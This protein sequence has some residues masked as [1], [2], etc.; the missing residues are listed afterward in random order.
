MKRGLRR[1]LRL[2]RSARRIRADVWEE[3]R[4]EIDMRAR[5]LMREGLT[6]DAAH[7]RSIAEFGDLDATRRYCEEADMEIERTTRRAHLIDDARSDAAIAWRAMRRTPGFA[8][9]VLATLALGIGANT[10]VFSVVRRVLIAPLPFRESNQLYRLYTVPA[11]PGGDD[12]K[13][14]AAELADLAAESHS[15]AGVTQFGA[16]GGV[17]YTDDETAEPWQ[18]V[19]VAPNF[20]DVLGIRPAL[21]RPF[22]DDDVA[23]GT[24]PVVMISYSL[25]QRLFGGDSR[26]LGREMQLSSVAYTVIGVLP[27]NFVGP[28]FS[29]GT[30]FTPDA[31]LPLNV[32]GILRSRGSRGRVWRSVARLKTGVTPAALHAELELLRPRMQARYPE[33]KRAGVIRPVPL[34][35]AMAGSARPVLEIVMGAAMLVLV[36]TCVN[37]A[38]LFLARAAARKRELGVRAALGAAR[39]RLVRQVL[40]ESALYGVAGGSLGIAL[41]VVMKRAL[42]GL[43]GPALPQMGEVRLDAAVLAFAALVSIGCGLIVGVVPALAATRVDLRDALSESGGHG[44]SSGR[45]RT[46][47]TATL[48]GAQMAFAMVL[49]IGAGLLVRSFVTLVQRDVGYNVDGH[50]LTFHVNLPPRRFADV[51]ARAGFIRSFVDRARAVPGVT[52]VGYTAVAPWNGGWMTE[53][54][55]VDGRMVDETNVPTVDYETASDDFFSTIRVPLK[56]GRFF[57]PADRP[58]SVP[59]VIISESVAK[60]FWPSANPIGAR[61]HVDNGIPADSATV[62]EV[63]GVVGDVRPDVTSGPA[64]TVYVSEGQRIGYGGEFVVRARGDASALVPE[65]KVALHELDAK[66]PLTFARTLRDVF[67]ALLAPQELATAL[68]ASFAALALIL[69]TLGIYT[70]V[71]QS[72]T[73]RT[74]EFGIR[75]AL[76][77]RRESILL[78]VLRQGFATTLAGVASGLVL[79]ALAS[80]VV[81]SLLSGVSTHDAL[82]FTVAPLAL[83]VVAMLACALP[84]RAATR[85]QPV[86]ALRS[87]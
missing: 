72:V 6:A 47:A 76:G 26:V 37:I 2:P 87:E 3:L 35:D 86:D 68:M 17:T 79:A 4:Y 19:A 48:A 21:G 27:Q 41:A 38:G 14:S 83:I 63:V 31:L 53:G 65:L 46:R 85:V 59:V 51:D 30:T 67:K 54:F 61:V 42:I 84:A 64:A 80:R 55:R 69:A 22:S 15:L 78:L 23:Q 52:D 71:A 57:G 7:E 5:E 9:V 66:I 58:G 74:R 29:T 33:I 73:A 44:A 39:G 60:R 10:T 28:A 20:F 75:A 8:L 62:W 36:I 45:S 16:Y 32:P 34:R 24:K 40:T 81:A 11:V 43:A 77:A 56:A 18:T 1:F 12:D 50:V 49:I 82:T 70:V 13:L 25:W